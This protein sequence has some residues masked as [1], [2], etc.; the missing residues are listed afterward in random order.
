MVLMKTLL[1]GEE[2]LDECKNY[3]FNSDCVK[4]C[5]PGTFPEENFKNC[6]GCSFVL[7]LVIMLGLSFSF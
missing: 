1:A 7:F 6:I 2:C 5:P 4:E 3:R